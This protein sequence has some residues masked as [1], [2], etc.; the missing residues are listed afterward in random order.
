MVHAMELHEI[1]DD[2]VQE[3]VTANGATTAKDA[4]E[5]ALRMFIR[6]RAQAGMRELRG[7]VE[8]DG[9]LDESRLSRMV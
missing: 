6:V 2:L 1:D 7:K 9:N 4:V 8:W 5:A 3:A